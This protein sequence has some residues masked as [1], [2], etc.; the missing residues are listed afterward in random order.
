MLDGGAIPAW[1]SRTAAELRE[2]GWLAG[3]ITV[4]QA[5]G[6][7]LEAVTLHTGLLAARHALG[8]ELAVVTQGPGNLGTGTRWGFSGVAC[9]EAINAAAVLGGRPI[10]S[11]RV[12]EA[13]PRERHRG[14]SHHSLTAYGRVALAA[15]DIVVP[16][17]PGE[18]G[19]EVRTA[20]ATL[21]VRHRLVRI[22]VD[23]LL[24]QL[25]AC[26]VR[27]SSMGRGLDD[28]PAC[29]LTAAAAGRYAA[30]LAR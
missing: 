23:G 15:A 25:R 12:S 18:F 2:L 17:L 24:D 26:P 1:F 6:G 7:D 20:A 27:L 22:R 5:F 21:G 3:T 10:G 19:D 16:D 8:A 28:D 11:L 9:G 14:I 29:F 30:S 13:D 4:G